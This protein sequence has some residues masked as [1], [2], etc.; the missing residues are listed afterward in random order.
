MSAAY[1]AV[2]E[3]PTTRDEPFVPLARPV[4]VIEASLVE[5]LLREEG[6]PCRVIGTREA[7]LI[8]VP[9]AAVPLRIEVPRSRLLEA[10]E[11]LA[12]P[13]HVD[14]LEAALSHD[15]EEDEEEDFD[16]P[17]DDASSFGVARRMIAGLL[18]G[19]VVIVL[20]LALLHPT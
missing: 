1:R 11:I 5:Q 10:E 8:G 2:P 14:P 6:I 16:A 3:T 13:T 15:D 20:A 7:A 18:L 4:D 19:A 17:V 9:Q 12:A